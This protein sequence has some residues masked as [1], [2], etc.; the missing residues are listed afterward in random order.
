MGAMGRPVIEQFDDELRG[1]GRNLVITEIVGITTKVFQNIAPL[2]L[3]R[4]GQFTEPEALVIADDRCVHRAGFGAV[5][6]H[7]RRHGHACKRSFIGG[8]EFG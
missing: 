5:D 3:R 7:W 4:G 2:G 6:A 8:F 1:Q